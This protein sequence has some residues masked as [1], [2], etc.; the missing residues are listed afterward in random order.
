VSSELGV[1]MKFL[2]REKTVSHDISTDELV[3]AYK[4]PEKRD[5][6]IVKDDVDLAQDALSELSVQFKS[7][8]E[9]QLMAVKRMATLTKTLTKMETRLRQLDR[10][11]SDNHSLT[12]EADQLNQKL[13]QS[14][15]LCE[16]Q[17]KTLSDL[18]R[19]RDE[20]RTQMEIAKGSLAQYEDKDATTRETLMKQMREIDD[21]STQ[22]MHK[23]ENLQTLEMSKE[24]LKED[25]AAVGSDLAEERNRAYELQKANEE[26]SS[27]LSEKTRSSDKTAAELKTIQNRYT[28][29]KEKLFTL[30]SEVQSLTYNLTSQ[31]NS[32]EDTIKRREDEVITL[33]NQNDQLNTQLRIKE[34]MIAHV[35]EELE[36]V[37]GALDIERS[38]TTRGSN[39][40]HNKTEELERHNQA[41]AQSKAEYAELQSKFSMA[42]EDIEALRKIIANQKQKLERYAAISG[43]ST[44]QVFVHQESTPEERDFTP[45]LKAI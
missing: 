37:R 33:K 9:A 38:R 36:T 4:S 16:D 30:K 45:H 15:L 20:F 27:R 17:E 5:H 11:E 32:F 24:T 42:I 19:Q 12:K 41:L 29:Q 7:G 28:D 44:G 6:A 39:A 1:E 8:A 25:L 14:S 2:K 3:R 43:G 23:D 34:N 40:L 13:K 22:L 21:L 10:V 35:E 26:L 18:R 31:K